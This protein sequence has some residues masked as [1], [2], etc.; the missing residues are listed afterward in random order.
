MHV[1]QGLVR[2]LKRRSCGKEDSK[3]WADLVCPF[4]RG[5]LDQAPEWL[6]CR[7]CGR[8]YPIVDGMPVF[9][10]S[11]DDPAWRAAQARRLA[12]P[13][14]PTD[15]RRRGRELQSLVS[16]YVDLGPRSRVLQVGP[17]AD[18]DLRYLHGRRY[19]IDPL[20]A[21]RQGRGRREQG[22]LKWICGRGEEL[23]FASGAFDA[24]VLADV[25]EWAETPWRVLTE[26]ERVLDAGGVLW[27]STRVRPDRRGSPRGRPSTA[28]F[29][30]EFSRDAL[31]RECRAAGLAPHWTPVSPAQATGAGHILR[32]ASYERFEGLFR[33]ALERAPAC[34]VLPLLAAA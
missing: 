30:R 15:G 11:A 28:S 23:P 3:M 2:A 1:D 27:L 34:Q 18:V 17:G 9:L 13:A 4:D 10:P 25:L 31:L 33:P 8:G 16:Q 22:G 24:V 21:A 6:S 7:E 12:N 26:A 32:M 5:A 19:A 14:P 20:A 29:P